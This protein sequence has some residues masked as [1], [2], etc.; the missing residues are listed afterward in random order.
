MA[1]STF[2]VVKAT[3][4]AGHDLV[5]RAAAAFLLPTL[6]RRF[7]AVDELGL[8][9]TPSCGS[10]DRPLDELGQRLAFT[11]DGFYFGANL[12]LDAGGGKVASVG[13]IRCW[14]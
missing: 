10:N 6:Y 14:H 4:Q 12:G 8:H 1:S 13:G 11:Q 3:L 7:A 2:R 5:D 9:A